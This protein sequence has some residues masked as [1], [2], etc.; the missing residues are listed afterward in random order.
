M[1][2]SER[3]DSNVEQMLI[4]ACATTAAVALG[5]A[6]QARLTVPL[7]RA[8]RSTERAKCPRVVRVA[9]AVSYPA[10]PTSHSALAVA[11]SVALRCTTGRFAP[12]PIVAS[13]MAFAANRGARLFVD[14][15]RP[16]GARKRLG[17]D[18]FG[19]P[20]G[21]TVGGTAVAFATAMEIAKGKSP[22][23]RTATYLAATTFA[24]AVGWSRVALD[25]H[26]ID[27][28]LGGW[29]IGVAIAAIAVSACDAI[30]PR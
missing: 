17:L 12:A 26:W 15:L 16:P 7:D 3:H 23:I 28:V 25:E 4:V 13:L 27:D 18:R 22:Q 19:F 1:I 10:A 14:Q 24:V 21:H 8:V 9:K 30:D 20:S 5:I 6:T 11:S 2:G 29:A